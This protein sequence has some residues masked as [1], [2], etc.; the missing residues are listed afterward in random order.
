MKKISGEQRNFL[1]PME[2]TQCLQELAELVFRLKNRITNITFELIQIDE[3]L[4]SLHEYYG[5]SAASAGPSNIISFPERGFFPDV[6]SQTE[7]KFFHSEQEP[8]LIPYNAS[9]GKPLP[10]DIPDYRPFLQRDGL[11]LLAWDKRFTEIG[12]R[13]TA[14]WVTSFGTARFYASK[15]Y[16]PER[17]CLAEPDRKSYAAEDGI[18]FYGQENPAYIVHVAP[19]LMMSNPRHRELRLNHIAVLKKQG[20]KVDF[21]Y[22]YLLS[23]KKMK[24]R[25]TGI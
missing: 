15:Q 20:S 9:P 24:E 21:N 14:Y 16:E 23:V 19:E 13:F 6:L 1:E 11:I 5:S 2:K 10:P 18:E 17:F 3:G 7:P 22:K 12:E 4:N 25:K 8:S